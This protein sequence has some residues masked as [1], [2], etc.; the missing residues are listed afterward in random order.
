MIKSDETKE[1]SSLDELVRSE[2]IEILYPTWLPENEK[3]VKVWY[4]VENEAERYIFQCDNAHHSIE[5]RVDTEL[6]EGLKAE[7]E[8]LTV[9]GYKIYYDKF[10]Q[11]K[12]ANLIHNNNIYLIR[13]D[14]EE[15]LFKII[16]NLKEIN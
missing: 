5:I 12:Q 9:G 10:G 11:Y 8:E 4:L 16:E 1:Y 13:S 7:C 2:E 15:N 6:A 3:I 14:T